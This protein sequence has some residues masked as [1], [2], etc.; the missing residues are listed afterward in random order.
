LVLQT[1][2]FSQTTIL[3]CHH[4]WDYQFC[5]V[6]TLQ[7]TFWSHWTRIFYMHHSQSYPP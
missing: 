7:T 5:Q 3:L 6:Q 4:P 1:L 2:E